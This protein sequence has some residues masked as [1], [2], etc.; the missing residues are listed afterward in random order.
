[1]RYPPFDLHNV[2]KIGRI[3]VTDLNESPVQLLAVNIVSDKEL[4]LNPHGSSLFETDGKILLYVVNHQTDLSGDTI[5]K[6]EYF[7]ETN[8]LLWVRSFSNPSVLRSVNDLIVVTEDEF[9]A[10]NDFYFTH[11]TTIIRT[12][13]AHLVIRLGSVAYCKGENCEIKTGYNL[14]MP[15]GITTRRVYDETTGYVL[16]F[17]QFKFCQ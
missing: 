17:E 7:V 1:M 5:E 2:P 9:F 11:D 8:T 16:N 10:T 15:N 14:A 4:K 3:Y 13:E 12:L 6:F